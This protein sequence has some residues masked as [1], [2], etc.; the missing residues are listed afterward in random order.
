MFNASAWKASDKNL[1]YSS[2][3]KETQKGFVAFGSLAILSLL[4]WTG[5]A[6]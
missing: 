5:L 6:P 1:A 4:A 3:T 2:P